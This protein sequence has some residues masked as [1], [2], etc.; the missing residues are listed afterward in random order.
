MEV[1]LALD[2]MGGDR[3]RPAIGPVVSKILAEQ[4]AIRFILVGDEESIARQLRKDNAQ[5]GSRLSIHHASQAVDLDEPPLQALRTKRD[6]SMRVALNLVKSGEADACVSVGNAA[7]LLV[8][9]QSVL[10]VLPGLEFPA[11]VSAIPSMSGH[12]YLLD[13]GANLNVNARG[14]MEFA[15]MGAALASAVDR[16]PNPKIALLNMGE[17][18]IKGG[19][20]VKEASERLDRKSVV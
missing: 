2:V 8:I 1:R 4:S 20:P 5:T 15:F 12:T 14:L 16:I 9:A 11:I 7:A 6:S 3:V 13:L 18:E 19:E 10:K 17:E